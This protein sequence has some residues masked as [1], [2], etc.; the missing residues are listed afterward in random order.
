L[1][2]SKKNCLENVIL[3][4]DFKDEVIIP[5]DIV[6][7]IAINIS[8]E[9]K[10]EVIE[11]MD[12]NINLDSSKMSANKREIK[13]HTFKNNAGCAITLES[14]YISFSTQNYS[15]YLEFIKL[16]KK[17]ISL[18]QIGN[19]EL[20]RLG[21][22]YIN[23]IRLKEGDPFEWNGYVVSSLTQS[24]DF[25]NNTERRELSR[26]M[27]HMFFKKPDCSLVF[28]YGWSNSAF[29]NHIAKKEFVLDYDCFTE[30]QI[31]I[32][33]TYEF[34]DKFHNEIKEMYIKSIGDKLKKRI[35]G[36]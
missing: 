11:R 23:H 6:G 17:V 26:N 33:E 3:R 27:G 18:L 35:D 7:G 34:I 9:F 22:R 10:Y 14:D 12:L 21:L 29:P 25:L 24:I 2:S 8:P 13:V 4:F 28:L 15:N 1:N 19:E 20:K 5:D 32:N 36:S 16:A 30:N 31:E